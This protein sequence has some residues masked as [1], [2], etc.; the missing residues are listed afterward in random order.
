MSSQNWPL[1][2]DYLITSDDNIKNPKGYL[3]NNDNFKIN[4]VKL[5]AV[6]C[7][8]IYEGERK[9]DAY[10]LWSLAQRLQNWIVDRSTARDFT[11]VILEPPQIELLQLKNTYIWMSLNEIDIEPKGLMTSV[12]YSV[13]PAPFML[14][15]SVKRMGTVYI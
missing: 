2:D 1:T 8:T 15:P 3:N 10:V 11:V 6:D 5:R 12:Q 7:Q 9:F 4:T 13:T 14:T